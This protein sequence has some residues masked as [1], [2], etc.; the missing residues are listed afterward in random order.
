MEDFL[1]GPGDLMLFWSYIY[2]VRILFPFGFWII[3]ETIF[4]V[5]KYYWI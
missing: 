3:Y 4:K 5:Y 2:T 1:S